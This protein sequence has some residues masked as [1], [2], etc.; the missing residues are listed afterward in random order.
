MT[1]AELITVNGDRL[2]QPWR[3]WQLWQPWQPWQSCQLWQPSG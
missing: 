3:T 1:D 2:W